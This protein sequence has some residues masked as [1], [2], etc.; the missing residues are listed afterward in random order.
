MVPFL[1]TNQYTSQGFDSSHK[2]KGYGVTQQ[3]PTLLLMNSAAT[4]ALALPISFGLQKKQKKKQF[5]I[6]T[7]QYI[8]P[9]CRPRRFIHYQKKWDNY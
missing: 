2:L 8:R 4:T 3:P 6:Y 5:K 1:K 9:R 7:C